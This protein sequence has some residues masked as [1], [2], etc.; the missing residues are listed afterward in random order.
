MDKQADRKFSGAIGT[1]VRAGTALEFL[2]AF[3]VVIPLTLW[4]AWARRS[5]LAELVVLTLFCLSFAWLNV[6]ILRWQRSLRKL[7]WSSSGKIS[8]GLGPRPEDPEELGIWQRGTHFRYS[9]IAV[10][11]CMAAF[12]LVKWLNGE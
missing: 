11:L 5:T 9:F 3:L 2:V 12:G 6:S 10:L 7:R 8:F 1:F 4:F